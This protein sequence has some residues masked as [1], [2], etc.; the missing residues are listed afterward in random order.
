MGSG[1]EEATCPEE[2]RE[3]KSGE[4][5]SPSPTSGEAGALPKLAAEQDRRSGSESGH[6][7]VYKQRRRP[8]ETD[9]H[10]NHVL[11]EKEHKEE[12]RDRIVAQARGEEALEEAGYKVHTG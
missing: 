12:K 3:E 11:K 9:W 1:E 8:A 10:E 4:N 2:R 5:L 6:L 7:L